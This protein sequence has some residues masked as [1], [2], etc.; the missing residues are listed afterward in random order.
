MKLR[1]F[2][3]QNCTIWARAKTSKCFGL[4]KFFPQDIKISH[5]CTYLKWNSCV[6]RPYH[7]IPCHYLEWLDA[8]RGSL[9]ARVLRWY[10]SANVDTLCSPIKKN[11]HKKLG[12]GWGP[13]PGQSVWW[14]WVHPR[15]ANR[16]QS[17]RNLVPRGPP[18]APKG[19]FRAKTGRFC[20]FSTVFSNWVVPN[21]L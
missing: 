17:G 13:I 3:L 4:Q 15:W 16:G 20:L 14:A 19:A 1:L 5:K 10:M 12:H 6:F 21:G 2:I 9:L 7:T 8:L 11:S 18:R